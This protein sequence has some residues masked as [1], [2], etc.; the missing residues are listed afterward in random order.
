MPGT[1]PLAPAASER[2][3]ELYHRYALLKPQLRQ[4]ELPVEEIALGIQHLKVAVEPAPVPQLRQANRVFQCADELFLL[5]ALFA[6]TVETDERV[7]DL[8]Q[9]RIDRTLVPDQ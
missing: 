2:A 5:G 9:R 4:R 8:A 6:E 7:R 3:I 1:H